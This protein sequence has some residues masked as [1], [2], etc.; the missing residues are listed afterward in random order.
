MSSIEESVLNDLQHLSLTDLIRPSSPLLR[1]SRDLQPQTQPPIQSSNS[2]LRWNYALYDGN[3]Y[4]DIFEPEMP[5]DFNRSCG[6]S[7]VAMDH[8]RYQHIQCPSTFQHADSGNFANR[9]IWPSFNFADSYNPYRGSPQY[10]YE[11]HNIYASDIVTNRSFDSWDDHQQRWLE[12]AAATTHTE[13]VATMPADNSALDLTTCKFDSAGNSYSLLP[14]VDARNTAEN[15]QELTPLCT[16]GPFSYSEDKTEVEE[17][18]SV[19]Q[20]LE[21]FPPGF[22]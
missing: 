10:S 15:N 13:H 1:P 21:N 14:N 22:P 4:K 12:F 5:T 6:S 18:E 7:A 8:Q 19:V 17:Y 20:D 16:L 3:F 11:Y 9:N 2:E